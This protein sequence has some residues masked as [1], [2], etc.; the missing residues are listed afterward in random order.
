MS[1]YLGEN[2]VGVCLYSIVDSANSE[3]LD[4]ATV[5][6]QNP[7]DLPADR[8]QSSEIE[9]WTR[10]TGWPNLDNLPAL[11]EGVYLTY[12]NRSSVD[13]KWAAFCCATTGDYTIA[14]GHINDS[15]WVQDSTQNAS[16]GAYKEINYG[17]LN[18]NYDYLVFKIT[19]TSGKHIIRFSFA[20]VAKATLDTYA[21]RQWYDQYCLERK[22]NLPYITTTGFSNNNYG[23]CTA[24][25]ENDN[26]SIGS[27]NTG[28][29]SLN[30]AFYYGKNLKKINFDNWPTAQWNVTSIT[31][32]FEQCS[33]IQKLDLNNWNTTNWHI[34][35]ITS[36]FS[37]CTSLK[38]LKIFNWDLTNWGNGTNKELSFAGL[39]NNCRNLEELDLSNWNVAPIRVT[40][41]G[42]TWSNCYRL[43]KLSINTWD[44]SNWRVTRMENC[45][46]YCRRLTGIDLS[47][48]DVSQWQIGRAHV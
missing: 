25:M 40:H 31:S 35:G 15:N 16:N 38:E 32:M 6:Q 37:G 42:S 8:W 10:P 19:P 17:D 21:L 5:V 39:F 11:D 23:Y 44:T 30:T 33:S 48:W 28:N 13:Y 1:V 43:K 27:M 2:K 34:A 12:D 29:M 14:I 4:T 18:L 36:L 45:F 47:N 22:G 24:W 7:F 46:Y 41:L 9:E 26:T 20:R 3:G